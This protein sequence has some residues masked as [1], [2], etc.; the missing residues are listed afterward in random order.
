[1]HGKR[2]SNDVTIKRSRSYR[3]LRKLS[4]DD[5]DGNENGK[6]NNRFGLAKKTT[7]YVNRLLLH[8][9]LRSLQDYNVKPPNLTFY[10]KRKLKKTIFHF[11]SLNL[12]LNLEN[13]TL[14]KFVNI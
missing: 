3:E 14:E 6:N 8:T 4:N 10:V 5:V 12:V 1:M 7:L 13:L 11:L 9:S 2:F